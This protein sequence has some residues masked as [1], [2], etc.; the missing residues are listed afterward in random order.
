MNYAAKKPD[1]DDV[2]PVERRASPRR[3]TRF[4]ATVVYGAERTT[5]N[6]V[7][8][9][10]SDGGACIKLDATEDLPAQ[11]HLIWIA[12]R[13]V[14]SAEAVWRSKGEMGVRFLSKHDIQGRLSSELAAVCRAWEQRDR[15]RA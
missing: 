9:N 12:D 1:L 3:K 7:V 8:K 13:A 15:A 14:I 4:K 10:L 6:C 2:L 11:F 5:A